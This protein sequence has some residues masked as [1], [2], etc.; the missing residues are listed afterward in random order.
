MDPGMDPYGSGIGTEPI[1][2]GF[3]NAILAQGLRRDPWT[4]ICP[5]TTPSDHLDVGGKENSDSA[6]EEARETQD[7]GIGKVGRAREVAQ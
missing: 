2:I 5:P 3:P 7:V 4:K 6:R 1:G